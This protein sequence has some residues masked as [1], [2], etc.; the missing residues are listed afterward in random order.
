MRTMARLRSWFRGLFRRSR[1]EN[2]MDAELRFHLETCADDFARQ[3]IGPEEATRRA[4]LEFGGVEGRKEDCRESLGLRL[5]DELRADLR[6][7]WRSLA[8][9]PGFTAV[10]VLSL[11]LGIGVNTAIFTLVEEALLKTLAVPQ[12]EELRLLTWVS[13]PNPAVHS[14][15]GDFSRT[16]TGQRTSSSFS[17]P[18][19]RQLRRENKLFQDLFA[20]KEAS[21]MTAVIDG[22]A[23]IV[24][25]EFVSGNLYQVLGARTAVGRTIAPGDD[26]ESGIAPVTVISDA[27][28]TRRFGR[29][30]SALGESV[31][32]NGTPMTIVGVNSPGFTG[33][34]A[35]NS[36][37][38]FVPLSLRPR[39]IPQFG[40]A[41]LDDPDHW[42]LVIM[43]RLRPGVSG[44]M[45][46]ASLDGALTHAVKAT[47]TPA[48][49]SDLPHIELSAG[50]RGLDYLRRDFSKPMYVL[51][52]LSGL[53]LLIACANLANLLLARSAAR[54][55]EIGVRMALGAGRPRIVRQVLTESLLLAA[56]GGAAGLALG[57]AGRHVI[58]RLLET[59]WLP[60]SIRGRFDWRVLAFAFAISLV[61]GFLF[62]LAPAWRCTRKDIN[63]GLRAGRRTA[64][65]HRQAFSGKAIVVFQVSL[66]ALLL[67]GAGLF[68]RTLINL[69]SAAIG[70]QP[71]RILLFEIEPPRWRYT[72]RQRLAL[73]E[74]VE[75]DLSA[76]PGVLSVTAS[77]DA[78]L[79]NNSSIDTFLP[80]GR[81]EH[82][83]E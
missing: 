46:R 41:R 79:A 58:P 69:Q 33:L 48:K 61:T 29:S 77:S 64:G 72:D 57:Y 66:S 2:E 20:F 13:G 5:W 73:F 63:A 25:G 49:N 17:F 75:R 81:R 30:L 54:E 53:V 36:P 38:V 27:F 15:W 59:P 16:K 60:G 31:E 6:L 22:H 7:G 65:G 26:A 43:G 56:L 19:Y 35:G 74:R 23:E 3:G 68:M 32:L 14:I 18:V 70:F 78:L 55:R 11:G 21:R 34:K 24:T 8:R 51:M 76:A 39:L 1:I 9:N 50:S 47:M 28:W 37:D 82:P 52:S 62:G 71:Q 83:G 10:A 67:I 40:G 45:A 80:T 12:P 44:A 4:R 42:W